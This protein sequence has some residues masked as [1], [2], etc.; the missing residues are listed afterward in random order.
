MK[1]HLPKTTEIRQLGFTLIELLVVIAVISLLIAIIVPIFSLAK[2]Q[3]RRVVCRNN[4]HLFLVAIHAYASGNDDALPSGL[5]G[6]P[7][8]E[9]NDEHTPVLSRETIDTLTDLTG[10]GQAM[11]CPWLRNQFEGPVGWRYYG[12]WFIG[13]NYLGGHQETPW[14]LYEPAE[15][16]WISPQKSTGRSDLLLVAELNTWTPYPGHEMSFA[17][18][19]KRGAI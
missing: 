5:P 15:E 6:L 3:A 9:E 13:Y 18:H 10:N 7:E 1:K 8:P 16:S 11:V 14:S 12:H 19:G 2:E 17:P 4:I